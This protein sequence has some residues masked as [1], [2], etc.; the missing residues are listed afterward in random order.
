V[1]VAILADELQIVLGGELAD[2]LALRVRREALSLLLGRLTNV[3]H[4]PPRSGGTA[5]SFLLLTLLAFGDELSAAPEP[6]ISEPAGE[7]V[8]FGV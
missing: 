8:D 5:A 6:P 7:R 3:G 2:R 1:K 4:R